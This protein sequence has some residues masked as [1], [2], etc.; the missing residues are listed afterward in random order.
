[1]TRPLLQAALA[2][3]VLLPGPGALGQDV[4]APGSGASS[5]RI[6]I[7][8]GAVTGVYYKAGNALCRLIEEPKRADRPADPALPCGALMT[9]GSI[10]NIAALRAGSVD[11]ALV[12]SDIPDQ[13]VRGA[14]PFQGRAND[15][16]RALFSL[17]GEPYQLLVLRSLGLAGFEDLKGHK[18]NAGQ[19]GT[20]PAEAFAA[21]MRRHGLTEA[22]L[23]QILR[24]PAAD[25]FAAFCDGDI[26]ALGMMVGYPNDASARAIERCGGTLLSLASPADRA[27]VADTP[28]YAGA[29]IPRGAYPGID[30]DVTTFGGVAVAAATTDMPDATAYQIVR[31]VFER[32]DALRGMHPALAALDPHRMITD[33]ITAPLHPGAVRYF[34]ER[35]FLPAQ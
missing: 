15:R 7:G 12:Q 9:A 23:T 26:E 25:Q 2:C 11:A 30:R 6:V 1:M 10:P 22:S 34:H 8:T 28:A 32:L 35:G 16:L 5:P 20:A 27:M 31:D 14:G 13:A 33:G 24:P 17:H 21:L 18:V 29:V 19:T 3:I 4:P